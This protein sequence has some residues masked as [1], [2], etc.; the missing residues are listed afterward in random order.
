MSDFE[1]HKK[2]SMMQKEMISSGKFTFKKDNKLR[3]EYFKPF[4]YIFILNNDNILIKNEQRENN[5]SAKSNKLFSMVSR[6]TMDCVT[7]DVINSKDFDVQIF[8]NESKYKFI[9]KPR[10]KAIK[11]LISEIE[12]LIGKNDFTVEK[13]IMKEESGDNTTLIF[14]NKRINQLVSDE[15]FTLK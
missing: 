11:S 4:S 5:Y 12:V 1:Q 14:S 13:I 10:L 3:M 6:L 2:V 7:G 15:V 8:E 9:L